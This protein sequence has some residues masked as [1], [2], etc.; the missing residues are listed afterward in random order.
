MKKYIDSNDFFKDWMLSEM[1]SM[2]NEALIIVDEIKSTLKQLE[3]L[4]PT[5]LEFKL[6]LYYARER[7]GEMNEVLKE[8]LIELG[9]EDFY[10]ESR[11]IPTNIETLVR[12][13]FKILESIEQSILRGDY[14]GAATLS[15]VANNLINSIMLEGFPS[16]AS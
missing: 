9:D 15:S 13:L 3:I 12:N 16:D 2:T 8:I 7:F 4:T 10:S 1:L 6:L 11:F 5:S 14:R